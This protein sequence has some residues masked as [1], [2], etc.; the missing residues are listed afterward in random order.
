MRH[1]DRASCTNVTCLVLL[2]GFAMEMGVRSDNR[3][4]QVGREGESQSHLQ[5]ASRLPALKSMEITSLPVV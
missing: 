2:K 1:S 3:S 4:D 5:P